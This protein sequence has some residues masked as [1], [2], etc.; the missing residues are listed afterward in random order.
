MHILECLFDEG[1]NRMGYTQLRIPFDHSYKES[2]TIWYGN[3]IIFVYLI[4]EFL[5]CTW[6]C[7]TQKLV[8]KPKL[9]F[10]TMIQIKRTIYDT[11]FTFRR[12]IEILAI[13]AINA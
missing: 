11:I 4:N 10:I 9:V 7:N 5:S 1:D 2:H 12:T 3:N 13:N 6:K 8:F